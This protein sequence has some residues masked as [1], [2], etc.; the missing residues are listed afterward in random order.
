[1]HSF[2]DADGRAWNLDVTIPVL[3]RVRDALGVE[4]LDLADPKSDLFRKVARD[5]VLLCDMLF[6]L[7]QKAAE[8]ES[9]ADE[10]FGRALR[11][12][13][14]EAATDA[15]MRAI[16]DFFPSGRKAIL[17]SLLDK[18]SEYDK[19]AEAAILERLNSQQTKTALDR[20]LELALWPGPSAGG[21]PESS[22]SIRLPSRD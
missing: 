2:R 11:G 12:D 14:L 17:T 19:R 1:M 22:A 6:V 7:C 3:R 5:P 16:A 21:L 18:M 9:V 15:L 13:A 10:Q 20:E 8:A 4:L